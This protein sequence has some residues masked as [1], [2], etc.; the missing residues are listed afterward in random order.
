MVSTTKSGARNDSCFAPCIYDKQPIFAI[1]IPCSVGTAATVATAAIPIIPSA[2]CSATTTA[3]R[4][5][6]ATATTDGRCWRRH[7]TQQDA[8]PAPHGRFWRSVRRHGGPT[9]R[10]GRPIRQNGWSIRRNGRLRR[11]IRRNGQS[12][13]RNAKPIWRLWQPVR[14]HDATSAPADVRNGRNGRNGRLWQPFRRPD[15]P[16]WRYEPAV[17]RHEGQPNDGQADGQSRLQRGQYVND[18]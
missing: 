17:W 13:W 9:G 6:D 1:S 11:P 4:Q 18:A 7:V 10:H 14:R 5:H 3:I 12:I 8:A 16:I 15:G 2:A